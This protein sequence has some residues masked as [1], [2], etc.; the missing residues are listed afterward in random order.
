MLRFKSFINETSPAG[1][2]GT[3]KAMKKRHK[4]EIDNPWALTNWMKNQGYRS[5]KNKDGTKK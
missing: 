4:G 3:V 2:E 1:W 5:H